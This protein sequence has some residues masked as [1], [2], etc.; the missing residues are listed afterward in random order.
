LFALGFSVITIF[1][2]LMLAEVV[3]FIPD[4]YVRMTNQVLELIRQQ[5]QVAA[6]G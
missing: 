2:L 3:R 4:H 1:G 5:M 6:N